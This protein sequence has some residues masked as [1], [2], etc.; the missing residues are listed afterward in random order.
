[1]PA[2]SIQ[3]AIESGRALFVGN[4]QH[5][6]IMAS[7]PLAQCGGQRQERHR[8]RCQRQT[9]C[10]QHIGDL[11]DPGARLADQRGL[12]HSGLTG[13]QQRARV[14][15]GRVVHQPEYGL[16]LAGTPHQPPA[17]PRNPVRHLVE[18]AIA[19]HHRTPVIGGTG[20]EDEGVRPRI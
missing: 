12:P 15:T 7:C 13:D 14:P 1:M 17:G 8:Q 11:A 2:L 10:P 5:R 20:F 9:R 3:P 4:A 19:A 18:S 16:D 6:H